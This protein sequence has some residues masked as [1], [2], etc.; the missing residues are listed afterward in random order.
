MSQD[1]VPESP[2]KGIPRWEVDIPALQKVLDL[3]ASF[4]QG[5]V[6]FMSL[7]LLFGESGAP[8]LSI[9]A[10][11]RDYVFES[12][13][14]IHNEEDLYDPGRKIFIR[15]PVLHSLAKLYP[16]FIFRFD[17]KG[18]LFYHNQFVNYQ[19]KPLVFEDAQL[20]QPDYDSLPHE[21]LPLP[22]LALVSARK[23]VDFAMRIA[24]NKVQWSEDRLYGQFVT[25]AFNFQVQGVA[26]SPVQFRKYD[27]VLMSLLSSQEGLEYAL[28]DERFYVFSGASALSFLRLPGKSESK[29]LLHKE[30]YGQVQLSLDHLNKVLGFTKLDA[31]ISTLVF[32][33]NKTKAIFARLD[34]SSTFY[35]GTGD[36]P[37]YG[38][39][40]RVDELRRIIGVFPEGTKVV[41]CDIYGDGAEFSV[42]EGG[43]KYSFVLGRM[44][45]TQTTGRPTEAIDR[46]K[47]SREKE[48]AK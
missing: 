17:E 37:A 47:V 4:P 21:I 20:P 13:I 26:P 39:S 15:F 2:Y 35:V 48:T 27:M 19:I 41:E 40:L 23:M 9:Y 44:D 24:D 6:V 31:A 43:V 42:T 29:P 28:D 46:L 3:V 18:N 7:E 36:I 38:F 8:F 30:K 5:A 25:Y 11:N 34:V 10:T 22:K 1:L 32:L 45:T 12:V 16:D 33:P 14:A